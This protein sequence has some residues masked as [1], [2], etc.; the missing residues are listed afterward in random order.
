[1]GEIEVS[2]VCPAYNEAGTIEDTV[3]SVVETLS[4]FLPPQ[5]FE[6]IVAE[7]GCDD[8]TPEIA[9]RLSEGDDRIRHIHSDERLGR[10]AA[11]SYAFERAR[12]TVLVYL[13]TDMATDM[14]HLEELVEAVRTRDYDFAT[15]SRWLPESQANRPVKRGVPSLCY[16]ALVRIVLRSE[17]QDHQC[18]F[19]AFDRAALEALL[20][21]VQD[22]HWFWDTEVLVKAQY[23]GH[24]IKEFPVNWTPQEDS[25]VDLVRDVF[26]MGSQILRMW[27]ELRN[28]ERSTSH[29]TS[30]TESA[31]SD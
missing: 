27:W 20:P 31:E 8:R 3:R 6:V 17:L 15:G 13:D 30:Q 25:K 7:D 26:G 21:N 11:L 10:G 28:G 1:M 9:T 16:N 12:G 18:G 4:S 14:Q 29:T 24:R 5:S 19:K 23:R 22:D 2:V